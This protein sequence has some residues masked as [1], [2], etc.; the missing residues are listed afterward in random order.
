MQFLRDGPD[1][2]DA[3]L[4][5]HADGRVVFFCGAGIY[6][7]ARLRG[8]HDLLDLMYAELHTTLT[9]LKFKSLKQERFDSAVDLLEHRYPGERFAVRKALAAVFKPKLRLPR[10]TSTHKALLTLSWNQERKNS[11]LITTNFDRIFES[12]RPET[13]DAK[14]SSVIVADPERQQM[15]R[16]GIPARLASK[17][18]D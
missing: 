2:P 16:V 5:E 8:F 13:A 4:H 15:E 1:L 11:R 18:L 7:P 6:Y 12:V 9:P 3:L 17:S 14:L 10:A